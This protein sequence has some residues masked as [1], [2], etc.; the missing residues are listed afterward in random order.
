MLIIGFFS[1]ICF[2][3]WIDVKWKQMESRRR[4][5]PS[6]PDFIPTKY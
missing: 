3:V 1:G 5:H 2:C 6:H 4:N